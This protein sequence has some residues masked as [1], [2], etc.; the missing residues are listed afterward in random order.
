MNGHFELDNTAYPIGPLLF[1]NG[2]KVTNMRSLQPLHS[3]PIPKEVASRL[4]SDA[5]KLVRSGHLGLADGDTSVRD[6]VE[7]AVAGL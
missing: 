1:G 2:Y 6:Y 4:A 7:A 3:E 5:N